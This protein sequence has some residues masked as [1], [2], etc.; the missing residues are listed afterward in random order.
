MIGILSALISSS[1]LQ[2]DCLLLLFLLLSQ[3]EGFDIFIFAFSN[4]MV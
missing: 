3:I 1:R 4:I 2:H